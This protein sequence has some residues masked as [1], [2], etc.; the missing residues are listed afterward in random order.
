MK[1]MMTSDE[2]ETLIKTWDVTFYIF[3]SVVMSILI[4]CVVYGWWKEDKD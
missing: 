3:W 4:A 1:K 2:I